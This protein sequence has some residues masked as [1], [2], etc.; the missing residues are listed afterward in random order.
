MLAG[1]QFRQV[2]YEVSKVVLPVT[3]VEYK[4]NLQTDRLAYWRAAEHHQRLLLRRNYHV[5]E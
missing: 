2:W 4:W 3:F 1:N 5:A